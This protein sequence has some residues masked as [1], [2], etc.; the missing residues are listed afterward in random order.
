MLTNYDHYKVEIKNV[1]YFADDGR[2]CPRT[3][4]V[5]FYNSEGEEIGNELFGVIEKQDIYKIIKEG[6][7][8]ILDNLYINDFSLSSYR[9]HYNLERKTPVI[10]NNLSAKNA[11]F[12]ATVATDFGHALF[13][14]GDISFEG[15]QFVKGKVQF[16]GCDFGKGNVNFSNTLFQC[17]DIDFSGSVFADGDFIF[18]NSV[19]KDGKKDFQDIRFGKGEINFSNTEFN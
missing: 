8:L 10:I 3:A 17:G 6:K 2:I 19:I 12:E 18:K 1:K 5:N 15:S 13:N 16:N 7:D 9:K 4:I 11:L 14:E